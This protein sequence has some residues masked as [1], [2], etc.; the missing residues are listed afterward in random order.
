MRSIRIVCPL[1]VLAAAGCGRDG[2]RASGGGGGEPPPARIALQLG[3]DLPPVPKDRVRDRLVALGAE[4]IAADELPALPDGSLLIALGDTAGR[5]ELVDDAEVA[6]AGA[7]GFVLR[8]ADLGGVR[9]LAADGNGKIPY[10]AYAALEELG[11]AFLHPLDAI[12]PAEIAMPP[13]GL[14]HVEAPRWPERGLQLHTMH[15]LELT[16][17]LQGWGPGGPGD[18]N[19]WRALLPEWEAYLEWSVANRQNRVHWVLLGDESW[20][21]F[22]DDGTRQDRLAELVAIGHDWGHDV[23]VDVPIAL[24]QQHAWRLVREQGE[25][26]EEYDQ[27]HQRLD[28]LMTAGFDYVATEIG[29]SEFTH[30]DSQ[31]MLDWMDE[32]TAHL[33]GAWGA[34]LYIKI[35]VSTGQDAEGFTDPQTGGPLNYNFLPHYADP[36]LGVMPHTVQHYAFDDPAPTYGNTDFEFIFDFLAQEAGARPVVWHP[37]TAYWVSFDIDVPLFLPLYAERRLDDLRRIGHAEDAGALGIG[38]NAGA[39]IQGQ[40]TFS[41]G[42]EWGYWLQEVVTARAAWDPRLDLGDAAA[43]EAALAPVV[44]PFGGAKDDV[45]DLLV[46]AIAAQHALLVLGDYGE[47]APA[48]VTRR[49]GQAYLQGWETWDE[50]GGML[51][52][53]GLAKIE[54][55]PDRIGLLSIGLANDP[56][57]SDVRP[58][59]AAMEE[60]FTAHAQRFEA[61]EEDVA[62]PARPLFEEIR[63]GLWM[64]ALRA[65]QVHALFDVSAGLFTDDWR[66][67]RMAYADLA[68]DR[69]AQIAAAREAGFRVD[70]ERIAGWGN[71]PTSYEFGYLWTARTLH[72]W[73]RDRAKVVERPLGPCFRNIIDPVDTAFGEGV[74]TSVAES[75]ADLADSW[76]L[77]EIGEC[78]DAPAAEPQFP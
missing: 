36:R 70:P 66:A 2:S 42:W 16:H 4:E 54:T 53:A 26:A 38:A 5:R 56:A 40:S 8:T 15:P 75:V 39:R 41:S 57:Y 24:H 76:G 3:E 37:E 21:S 34:P 44:R 7:E 18:E 69:A 12:E 74:Y 67:E 71:N 46:E 52:Q 55:Q 9:V 30:P 20:G 45:R 22:S 13:A 78:L 73:R 58:L 65:Q 48:D 72:F 43:L 60:T 68:L 32:A 14:D 19:G 77:E 10:A 27:I 31:R 6:A 17:V 11:F 1:L 50:V 47:G 59:L 61:L 51:E 49:N 28:Y 63:D 23:G 29:T 25:L 62:D 64:N 35:H 33:A